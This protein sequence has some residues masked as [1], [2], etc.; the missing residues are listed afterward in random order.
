MTSKLEV[1]ECLNI[2]CL[3]RF[4]KA[5]FGYKSGSISA[6]LRQ[7]FNIYCFDIEDSK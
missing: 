4:E 5:L 2:R 6:G 1:Q 7:K 3:E